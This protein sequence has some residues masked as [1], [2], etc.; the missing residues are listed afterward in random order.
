MSECGQCLHAWA[1]HL[2]GEL[3]LGCTESGCHC[4][5]ETGD[6]AAGQCAACEAPVWRN[7]SGIGD[8]VCETHRVAA[9]AAMRR[10]YEDL[11]IHAPNAR[12]RR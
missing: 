8:T 10:R 6:Y 3:L 4:R 7:P 1:S 11:I 9:Q 5:R 12:R 2:L